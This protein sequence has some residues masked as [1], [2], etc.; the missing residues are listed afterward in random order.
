MLAQ[1]KDIA[2]DQTYFIYC[3]LSSTL[4]KVRF[5]LANMSKKEVFKLAHEANLQAAKHLESQDF[6]N[7]QHFD[8]LFADK[9]YEEGKIVDLEGNILGKHKGIEH[10]TI[11]Q[12]KGLG[13]SVS[14]PVYVHTIDAT[15][16]QIVLAPIEALQI[17]T[18]IAD[19]FVW[20]DNVEPTDSF[21]ASVK[22]RLAST[23]VSAIIERYIP[24]RHETFNGQAWKFTF[25]TPQKAIAPGQSVVI[26]DSGVVLGGGIIVETR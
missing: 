19:D 8:I 18:F 12:R 5:P 10:Y 24:K 11:G 7:P 2:K 17:Q 25:V 16:K 1:A 23:V 14:Y 21:E 4:A 15:K 9:P 13:V 22:T 6:I 20:P 26:Y 3:V